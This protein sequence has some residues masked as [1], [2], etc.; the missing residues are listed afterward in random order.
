MV[1]RLVLPLL[2]LWQQLLLLW[3][4]LSLV[5]FKL[6]Y[7]EEENS[8][9]KE[10]E[11]LPL[12]VMVA[13]CD[14]QVLRDCGGMFPEDEALKSTSAISLSLVYN[15]TTPHPTSLLLNFPALRTTY[16]HHASLKT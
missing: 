11:K 13:D 16:H 9:E 14:M 12:S 1:E 2:S 4:V 5:R 3:L 7:C 8:E 15:L 6:A 10:E